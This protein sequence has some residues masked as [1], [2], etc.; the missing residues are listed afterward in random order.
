MKLLGAASNGSALQKKHCRSA[1]KADLLSTLT[2]APLTV[3][4]IAGGLIC[5][6]YCC[7]VRMAP[8]T[9]FPSRVGRLD[10]C[11]EKAWKA[12]VP[13]RAILGPV[14]K[15]RQIMQQRFLEHGSWRLERLVWASR[16]LSLNMHSQSI[17]RQHFR[18]ANKESDQQIFEQR[19][20]LEG[21]I[22]VLCGSFL[23]K[24]N[25]AQNEMAAR[26]CNTFQFKG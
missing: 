24:E 6:P 25:G 13:L 20:V 2:S 4:G 21:L 19:A 3:Y 18:N 12:L 22:S 8:R 5:R 9:F 17:K 15:C 7:G 16:A 14:L 10:D 1:G 23:T 11:L 26:R